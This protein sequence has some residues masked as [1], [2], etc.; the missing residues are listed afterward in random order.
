MKGPEA[1]DRLASLLCEQGHAWVA[2]EMYA[3][4]EAERG[5]LGIEEYVY[6]EAGKYWPHQV[7]LYYH[8]VF[9]ERVV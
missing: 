2:D 5:V 3:D 4:L 1:F 8:K 9:R 7:G 6:R